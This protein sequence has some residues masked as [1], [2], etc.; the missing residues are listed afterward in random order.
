[1]SNR[2]HLLLLCACQVSTR[3]SASPSPCD[4]SSQV[5]PV[6]YQTIRMWQIQ[7]GATGLDWKE[8]LVAVAQPQS[9]GDTPSQ[10]YFCAGQ[11][12]LNYKAV[13]GI[14]GGL[15]PAVQYEGPTV[16]VETLH[17]LVRYFVVFQKRNR[18]VG[19][20]V[21]LKAHRHL[22]CLDFEAWCIVITVNWARGYEFAWATSVR[23]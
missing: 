5:T 15:Y 17:Y 21:Y 22:F 12:M 10:G 1:M 19:V 8:H 9:F 7:L 4:T 20:W 16:Y 2:S 11:L 14:P 23:K 3:S 6:R 18:Q 13:P